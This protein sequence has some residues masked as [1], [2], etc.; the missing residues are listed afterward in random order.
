MLDGD[1]RFLQFPNGPN[2]E[3]TYK[4]ST[5]SINYFSLCTTICLKFLLL[6]EATCIKLSFISFSHPSVA[7]LIF[8]CLF[9]SLLC[10]FLLSY[11]MAFLKSCS[12]SISFFKP[13]YY[14]FFFFFSLL[15]SDTITLRIR[16]SFPFSI[17]VQYTILSVSLLMSLPSVLPVTPLLPSCQCPGTWGRKGHRPGLKTSWAC[18][19][20]GTDRRMKKEG[21]CWTC[22]CTALASHINTNS[23]PPLRRQWEKESIQI[24]TKAA[25]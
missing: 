18:R 3:E 9:W 21:A 5:G 25:M 24:Q 8:F 15:G 17:V 23:D 4:F 20:T 2:D 1:F 10:S 19:M 6:N 7:F 16:F 12:I 11:C 13:Y 14:F 22:P